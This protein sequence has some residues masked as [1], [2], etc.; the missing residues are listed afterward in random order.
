[1]ISRK[2]LRY[3][4]EYGA[5]F[6]GEGTRAQGVILDLSSE[7]C[8]ARSAGTFQKGDFFG[9]LIDV[10]RYENP[11]HVILAAVRWSNNHEFGMEFIQMDP[12]DQQRLRQLITQISAAKV[13]RSEHGYLAESD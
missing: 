6:L 3:H 7:G 4:V 12:D 2:Y 8:R 5:S 9:V 1:M 11:L 10:P 13:L